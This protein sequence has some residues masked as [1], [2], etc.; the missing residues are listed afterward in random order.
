MMADATTQ[1]KRVLRAMSMAA[2]LGAVSTVMFV[3][4]QVALLGQRLNMIYPGK[5]DTLPIATRMIAHLPPFLLWLIA[6]TLAAAC[7]GVHFRPWARINCTCFSLLVLVFSLATYHFASAAATSTL[8]RLTA[9]V[10]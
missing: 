10:K 6:L 7:I 3:A 8:F 1:E 9:L 4:W 2:M 5:A